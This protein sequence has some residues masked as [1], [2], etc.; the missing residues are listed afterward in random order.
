[1]NSTQVNTTNTIEQ[2]NEAN[3][4]GI[5]NLKYIIKFIEYNTHNL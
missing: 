5:E 2:S 3:K 4:F 1:M